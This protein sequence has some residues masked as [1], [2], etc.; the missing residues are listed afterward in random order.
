MK[1]RDLFKRLGVLAAAVGVAPLMGAK[2]AEGSGYS[3]NVWTL[4]PGVAQPAFPDPTAVIVEM[5][6]AR[7]G[8][9]LVASVPRMDGR[10]ERVYVGFIALDAN[11]DRD[12]YA[13]EMAIA[14]AQHYFPP[15]EP[16]A[17]DAVW[18]ARDTKFLPLLAGYEAAIRLQMDAQLDGGSATMAPLTYAQMVA[19]CAARGCSLEWWQRED[20]PSTPTHVSRKNANGRHLALG[21]HGE[22]TPCLQADLPLAAINAWREGLH[23]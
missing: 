8:L 4:L 7:Q 2:R 19:D 1:R 13:R 22:G 20:A 23:A 12:L 17:T 5:A 14:L 15:P 9:K 3:T 21:F 16:D 18:D 6:W 11:F 10:G